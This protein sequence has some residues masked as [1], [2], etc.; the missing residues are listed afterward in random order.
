MKY[1]LTFLIYFSMISAEQ[2]FN[3]YTHFPY[4]KQS[5][6]QIDITAEK[7]TR[8]H[9]LKIFKSP[10]FGTTLI[11]DGQVFLTESEEC[12]YH[13]MAVHT[14]MMMHESPRHILIIG[15]SDGRALKE[16]LKYNTVEKATLI[17]KDPEMTQFLKEHLPWASLEVFN[18]PKVDLIYQ[19]TLEFLQQTDQKFDVIISEEPI[20]SPFIFNRLCKNRLNPEGIVVSRDLPTLV[21]ACDDIL[22]HHDF[23]KSLY[24]YNQSCTVPLLS[25]APGVL[26]GCLLIYLSFDH[27][28]YRALSEQELKARLHRLTDKTEYYLPLHPILS[29]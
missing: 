8:Y 4:L 10:L 29:F 21:Y 9:H 5:F 19:D 3:D 17:E 16:V 18:H 27:A 23:R 13:E 20:S 26:R 24:K 7:Q 28:P 2:M 14:P 11:R 25:Y 1:L 12:F 22:K 15:G 6:R